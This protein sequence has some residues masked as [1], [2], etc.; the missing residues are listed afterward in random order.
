MLYRGASVKPVVAVLEAA[1]DTLPVLDRV[2]GEVLTR[3][4]LHRSSI[5]CGPN[6]LGATMKAY[7]PPA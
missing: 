1:D 6:H 2:G 7:S 5:L 4:R 3:L